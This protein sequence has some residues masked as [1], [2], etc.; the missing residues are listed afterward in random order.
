MSK[1]KVLIVEDEAIIADDIFDTLEE[2]GYE[3]LEPANT[4]TEAIEKIEKFV[5]DIAILD[6]QLSGKKS[7]IDLATRINEL[8]KFPFIFLSSNSDK[9]TLEEA[10]RVEPLAYLVKP[11][12]KEEI[13]TSIEV[14]LF[15]YSKRIEKTLDERSL[16]IQDALFL[17]INKAFIRLNFSDIAYLKSDHIYIEIVT[18]T[19]EK[20]VVRGSLNEYMNKLSPIF[21]RVH[22][23][24]IVNL[25]HMTKLEQSTINIG[26]SDISIGK[27]QREELIN[28]LNRG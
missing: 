25:Q 21:Y 12:N 16:I 22:R 14:A 2:L 4:F 10:K 7:G 3:V 26:G 6:I 9:I 13:Y 15:N 18:T 17:K 27:K 11:F 20:H 19:G 28:Q 1:V 8:Y 5:P 23:S 24:Y